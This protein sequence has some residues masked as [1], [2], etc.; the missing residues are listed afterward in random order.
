MYSKGV[1]L[2]H[3]KIKR[4]TKKVCTINED[5]NGGKFLSLIPRLYTTDFEDRH[6]ISLQSYVRCKIVMTKNW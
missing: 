6:I 5:L 3:L 4:E 1:L 2:K